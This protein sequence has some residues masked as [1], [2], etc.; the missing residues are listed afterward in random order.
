MPAKKKTPKFRVQ[1][2]YRKRVPNRWRKPKGIQSKQRHNIKSR[3]ARPKVGYKN[4]AGV[5]YLDRGKFN[6]TVSSASQM[7]AIDPKTQRAYIAGAVGRKK[8]LALLAIAEKKG[9]SVGNALRA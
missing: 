2:G 6:V 4:A 9:I 7:Q 3:G 8:R 5:R 1:Q